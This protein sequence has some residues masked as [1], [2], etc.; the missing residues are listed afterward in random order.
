MTRFRALAAAVLVSLIVT[1]ADALQGRAGGRGGGGRGAQPATAQQ[2]AA[3]LRTEY[4]ESNLQTYTTHENMMRYL[5]AVQG[6]STDMKLGV[7]GH[8]REGRE[9]PYAIFSRPNVSQP[10]E[11]QA[12]GKPVV[13]LAANVHGGE[14]TLRE[15][16]LVLMRDL[17]ARGTPVNRLL[18]DLV[19]IAAPQINPDGFNAS[20]RGNLWGIDLNRDYVKLEHPEIAAYVGNLINRWNPVLFIDGH[21]GG[22]APYNINYQCGSHAAPDQRITLLCDREIFPAINAK[23]ATRSYKGWYYQNGNERRWNT[24]GFEA[25]IGRNYGAFVN[26]I[27]ILFES[28]GGQ[29][30]EQAHEA[31]IMS[32][33]AV[34]EYVQRN[35]AKVV[36]TV[37]RA[38]R[39]TVAMGDSAK[40]EIVV[41]MRY[42][43][44]DYPVTYELVRG[45]STNPRRTI[46]VRSDSL[47]KKPIAVRTRARP[48]AYVLPRE[49]TE[50]VAMLRRHGIIVEHLQAP[51]TGEVNAYALGAIRYQ[52]E[53][54]HPAT[55]RV[56]VDSV[57]VRTQTFPK[58]SFVVRTGQVLGR[59]VTHML[60]PE[61][62]DNVVYWNTMDA[63]LPKPSAGGAA[64]AADPDDDEEPPAG[65][66]G[67]GGRGRGG[68]AGAAGAAGGAAA[69]SGGGPGRGGRGGGRG[70]RGGGGPAGPPVIPIYKLMRPTPFQAIMLGDIE[71]RR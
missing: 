33:T 3:P 5:Q 49:A 23:L 66:G 42:G 18:N 54:N 55:T 11:A 46:T 52:P 36:E 1:P 68:A 32:Y 58:G 59:L 39:E 43:P 71:V 67:R 10:W 70:G 13:I 7:Y 45:D 56:T 16:L 40:G 34:I 53:Y 60:E 17:A 20:T 8:T 26:S 44:E 24:G 14:R 19:I 69:D 4:E 31:G 48:W 57:V 37:T 47:M 29:T 41:Q 2:P 12:L 30:R 27:G 35:R 15:S 63:W 22:A 25:R 21:N 28:P 38:R 62:E 61:T 50:A 65:G 51:L 6:T 64:T 9:L